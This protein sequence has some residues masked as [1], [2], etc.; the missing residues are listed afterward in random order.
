ME[1]ILNYCF[2]GYSDIKNNIFYKYLFYNIIH[3]SGHNI[4]VLIKNTT[5]LDNFTFLNFSE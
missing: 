3:I 5:K 2:N 4:C 1:P